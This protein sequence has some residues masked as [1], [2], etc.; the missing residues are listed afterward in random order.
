MRRRV[1][2]ISYE[3]LMRRREPVFAR[4]VPP[5]E[6]DQPWLD[7]DNDYSDCP[8]PDRNPPKARANGGRLGMLRSEHAY[9]VARYDS[10]AMPPAIYAVVR[11]LEVEISE[12]QMR[13]QS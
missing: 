1:H 6:S 10:G 3:S 2:Q 13:R 4:P 8:L 12:M 11:K 5:P 9:L 7:D